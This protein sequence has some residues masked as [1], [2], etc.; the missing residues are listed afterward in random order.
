MKTNQQS[1]LQHIAFIP[2][3]NRR[4]AKKHAVAAQKRIYEKGGDTTLDIIEAAFE[5]D[6]PYVTFWASSHANLLSRAPGFVAALEEMTAQKFLDIAVHPLIHKKQVRVEVLGE[7]RGIMKPK[8]I[9]AVQTA[10]DAT[11]HYDDRLLTVLIG[12]DGRRERGAAITALLHSFDHSAQAI[13]EDV[14]KANAL[15]QRHSWTG[16]LPDVDLIVRSGAWQDPH[17]S[18]GFLSFLASESQLAFPEVLWPDFTPAILQT[19]L[20][21]FASRER[22][23]G[24]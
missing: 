22:R 4:W 19:T 8:T 14:L 3:G 16:H 17:N 20:E 6:I 18:A 12:Y 11:A 15:L 23:K 13:P 21:D 10:I 9:Q 2:D 7:W 24:K 1:S 5:A